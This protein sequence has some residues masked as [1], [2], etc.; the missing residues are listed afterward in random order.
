[1]SEYILI[2]REGTEPFFNLAAEEYM[3]KHCPYPV[4]MLWRNTPSVVVG[5][6]QNVVKEVNMAYAKAKGIKLIRRISGGG[7]VYHDLGNLNYSVLYRYTER[8]KVDFTAYL[9]PFI[10]FLRSLGLNA[11]QTGVSNISIEGYKCSGNACH[12]Y[13]NRAIYHGTLLF[14]ADIERL[15][16][17]I[18]PPSTAIV[19]D[20]A[21]NSVR[22]KVRNIK[23]QL[24]ESMDMNGFRLALKQ[25]LLD[26]FAA[27]TS[28]N[29]IAEHQEVIQRLAN[30]KYKS[31]DWNMAYS[32]AFTIEKEL[33]VGGV[34]CQF[35]CTV[36]KG[37]I[38]KVA[39][40]SAVHSLLS[41]KTAH[42]LGQM[43]D[44][45]RVNEALSVLSL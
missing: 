2:D 42:L 1:M 30:E 32:P 11:V 8:A 27:S 29:F 21:I 17:V 37:V 9:Q 15:Q 13:K 34:P 23:E 24:P 43:Y 10:A 22:V 3:V 28:H 45:E 4:I 19:S 12:L 16:E 25:Y 40:S 7:T 38:K 44:E 26:H 6:H 18:S 31:W 39:F 14:D 5:K 41:Q 35:F 20:K 36:S 33:Q